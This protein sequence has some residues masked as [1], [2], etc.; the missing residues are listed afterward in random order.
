MD[1]LT[2]L[3]AMSE[4]CLVVNW[5]GPVSQQWRNALNSLDANAASGPSACAGRCAGSSNAARIRLW[6]WE[7]PQ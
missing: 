4:D 7:G 5:S 6:M 2:G 3:K 1:H